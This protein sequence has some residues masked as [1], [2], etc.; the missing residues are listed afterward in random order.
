MH[1]RITVARVALESAA[2]AFREYQAHHAA[3]AEVATL[4]ADREAARQKTERNKRLAEECE[5]AATLLAAQ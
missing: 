4:P 1:D 3:R 5:G 2:R